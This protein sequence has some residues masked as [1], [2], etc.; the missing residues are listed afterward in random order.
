VFTRSTAHAYYWVQDGV[1][2]SEVGNIEAGIND[3]WIR[4]PQMACQ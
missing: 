3:Y 1:K 4:V 2:A